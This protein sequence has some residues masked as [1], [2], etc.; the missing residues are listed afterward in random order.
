MSQQQSSIPRTAAPV[1]TEIP[2][3]PVL[4]P[5][6]HHPIPAR[7]TILREAAMAN[8][9]TAHRLRVLIAHPTA[10]T[11][12]VRANSAISRLPRPKKKRPGAS[13]NAL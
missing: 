4:A 7:L 13:L 1:F 5:G 3:W 9:L 10:H 6:R 8:P 11:V 12:R 2:G